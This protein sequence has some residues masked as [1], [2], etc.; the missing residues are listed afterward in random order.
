MADENME[1]LM[2]E[3]SKYKEGQPPLLTSSHVGLYKYDGAH[4]FLKYE[5]DGTPRFFSRRESVKGG[6]PE[7]TNVL[8]QLSKPQPDFAG[9]VF[10][11]ELIH[12]GH[13]KDS[14]ESHRRLSGILV[15]KPEKALE[16]Q[17]ILGPV[18]A[19]LHNV[20]SPELPTFR[21]KLLHMKKLQDSFGDPSLL[22]VSEPHIG[23]E[24]IVKLIS[25]TKRTGSEGVIVTHL[26]TPESVNV[27]YKVKHKT[28]HNL[29]IKSIIQEIDKKGEP[30]QSMGAVV[31]ED[32]AGAEVATVGTGF[33]KKEREDAFANPAEWIG[34]LIQ[35]ESMGLSL[36]KL[37]S[38]VFNGD[39]DG[40]IDK[41]V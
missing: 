24:A 12:T 30:K 14:Q 6:Y 29:R 26:D 36:N 20:I 34:R 31:C 16:D 33:S 38:P 3:R 1:E 21:A 5:V 18:R 22:W 28:H 15:S 8:P 10:S 11:V 4:F 35:V 41:V 25:S 19:V 2:Y 27:R 39:A 40:E 23:P 37:R 7:R 13:S 9:K 32:A 17:R